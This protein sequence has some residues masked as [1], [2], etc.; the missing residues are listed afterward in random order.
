MFGI[1]PIDAFT[2]AL[3]GGVAGFF[4]DNTTGVIQRHLAQRKKTINENIRWYEEL[5]Q[6]TREIQIA[7][8]INR[9]ES[10]IEITDLVPNDEQADEFINDAIHWM[11]E[12]HGDE[13]DHILEEQ[14]FS[15]EEMVDKLF[16]SEEF[17]L[18]DKRLWMKSAEE[19]LSKIGTIKESEMKEFYHR[20][21]THLAVGYDEISEEMG[22]PAEVLLVQCRVQSIFQRVS[23]ESFEMIMDSGDELVD[24]CENE[25]SDLR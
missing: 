5:I 11:N 6:I 16:H 14:D 17:R 10:D 13:Y 2:A 1:P 12:V 25:L 21:K 22:E 9:R 20:L 19:R 18:L 24:L 8:I 4:A 23:D 15:F 3:I 7:A